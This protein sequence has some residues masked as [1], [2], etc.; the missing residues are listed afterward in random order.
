MEVQWVCKRC[1]HTTKTKGNL[2]VHL[3]RKQPCTVTKENVSIADCIEELT[4]KAFEGKY[5]VCE[6]CEAQFTTRQAKSKHKKTSCKGKPT[7][8]EAE[9]IN[10]I[11]NKD[12]V[13]EALQQQNQ[14]LLQRIE[15]IEEKI[16]TSSSIVNNN[17]TNNT[18]NIN[19]NTFGQEDTSYLTHDFLSYCL[20]N[21]RKGLTSLIENIHYNKEYPSNQNIRCKSLKQNI[22]EKYI[23]AEWRACDASNTLDELIRKGYRILNTHYT[24]H[25][26]NDPEVQENEMTQRA[27]EKFRYL[28]DTASNDYYAVKRELRILVKDRTLYIIASPDSMDNANIDNGADDV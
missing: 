26:M 14:M 11:V 22:F 1:E 16:G 17:T 25:F 23:D 24:E 27:L 2:L 18:I 13:I 8:Q 7:I 28:S 20:M 10:V 9:S 15:Q 19:L 4:K 3:N 12:D 6:E 21:P 5:H